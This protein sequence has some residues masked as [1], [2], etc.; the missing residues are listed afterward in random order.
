MDSSGNLFTVRDVLK[1]EPMNPFWMWPFEFLM[2]SSRRLKASLDIE[3]KDQLD[4]EK[5]KAYVIQKV[6]SQKDNWD[7]GVGMKAVIR[8]IEE[9]NSIENV[10]QAIQHQ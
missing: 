8:D 1:I 6:K 10:I 7:S 3:F 9:A 2:H 5:A 4:I